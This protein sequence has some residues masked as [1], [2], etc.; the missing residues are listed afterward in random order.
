VFCS[1]WVFFQVQVQTCAQKFY[2]RKAILENVFDYIKQQHI[3]NKKNPQ[4]V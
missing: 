1:D 2:D 4:E 3:M